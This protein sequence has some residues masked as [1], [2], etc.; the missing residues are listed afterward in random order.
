MRV[1][2]IMSRPVYSVRSTDPVEFAAALLAERK[3]TAAPV[4]DEIGALVGMV[5]EGDVLWQRVHADPT[6]HPFR[7]DDTADAL[8]PKT[9]VDVMSK[10]AVTTSLEADVAD[11]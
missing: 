5:S 2:D 4:L 3:I 10:R 7:V 9:V 8:R 1:K 11:V 6:A